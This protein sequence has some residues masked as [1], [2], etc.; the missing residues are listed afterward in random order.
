MAKTQGKVHSII[1][2][3]VLVK[4]EGPVSQNEICFI[5]ENGERL[6]AEVIKVVGDLAY[7]QVFESTRGLKPGMP[8]EFQNHMLEVS[9]GPGLL[10]KNFDGLQND[11]DKMT[12]VF[13]KR[14]EYTNPL[15]DD[16]KWSFTP[17]AKAGDKVKAADWLGNVKENWLDHK[18]MV[19]FKL[20]GG[21]RIYGGFRSPGRGIHDFGYDCRI[22]RSYR[23]R[24]QCHDGAEMAGKS[25]H[26][27]LC[28]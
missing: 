14:G 24:N 1:S 11:L 18:I 26:P 3:L 6:M 15:E 28:G 5:E 25:S 17:L 9:L 12:G 4:V 22:E 10:S 27:E 13:L 16:K 7:V 19:P 23:E 20:K 2:N 8:V 21:G